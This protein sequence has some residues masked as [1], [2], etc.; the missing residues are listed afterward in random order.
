MVSTSVALADRGPYNPVRLAHPRLGIAQG[1]FSIHGQVALPQQRLED[2]SD[3]ELVALARK[4]DHDAFTVL[5]DRYKH[6]VHWAVRRML[7]SG[8]V[9]D[10]TQEVFIRAYRAL[11]GFRAESTFK[12]WIYKIARNRCLSELRKTGRRG[13]QLSL[14]DTAEETIHGFPPPTGP[15]PHQAAERE[16]LSR[17][18]RE[19]VDELPRHYSTVLTL[20]Y[21]NR[22]RYEDIAEVMEVPLGT[23]KTH[24][25][26]A[27]LRLRDLVL[28]RARGLV[29]GSDGV[30]PTD[31]VTS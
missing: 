9:E 1:R 15:D 23:V 16:D 21:V 13:E 22:M 27:R 12:T 14:D 18:V 31:E 4:S 6:G 3:E 2:L 24:L 19:L 10:L 29:D 30:S 8:D 28:S 26:R 5:V 7:G 20:F 17:R 11:P 25:R